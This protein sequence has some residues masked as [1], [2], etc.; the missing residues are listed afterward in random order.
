[1]GGDS[2]EELG[3]VLQKK[4]QL[5]GN[6]VRLIAQITSKASNSKIIGNKRL[7]RST[8]AISRNTTSP[9]TVFGLEGTA[10]MSAPNLKDVENSLK[11]KC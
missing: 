3:V 9:I 10:A 7:V 8:R 4:D 5:K 11:S 1:M 6:G 2:R